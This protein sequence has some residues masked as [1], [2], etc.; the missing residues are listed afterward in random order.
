M[1]YNFN[2]DERVINAIEWLKTTSSPNEGYHHPNDENR[3]HIMANALA[4]YK[5][6]LDHDGVEYITTWFNTI[7][8]KKDGRCIR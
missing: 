8:C 7:C 2:V 4:H 6:P 3:L 1:A 5:V